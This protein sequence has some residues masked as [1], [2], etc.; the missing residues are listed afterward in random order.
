MIDRYDLF[1]PPPSLREMLDWLWEDTLALA[2]G[3]RM[4]SW[5]PSLG[6][7]ASIDVYQEGDNVVVEA[8]LPGVRPE[9]IAVTVEHG[10]LTIR[11]RRAGGGEPGRIYLLRERHADDPVYRVRLPATVDADA[12]QATLEHGIL[13]VSFPIAEAYRPRRISVQ[14]GGAAA[15]SVPS[16]DRQTVTARPNGH[17][18]LAAPADG[19]QDTPSAGKPRHKPSRRT[20]V[21][22]RKA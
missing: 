17:Q 21:A 3:S 12:A 14:A 16:D 2:G 11:G 22:S 10:I 18:A 4:P 15:L 6:G 1:T 5:P 13:R 7:R 19:Q 8:P 20:R 9:E